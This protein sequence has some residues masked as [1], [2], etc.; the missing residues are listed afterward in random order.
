MLLSIGIKP[1]P[2]SKDLALMLELALPL[3]RKEMP[4]MH[5]AIESWM[6][7]KFMVTNGFEDHE[8]IRAGGACRARRCIGRAALFRG[9]GGTAGLAAVGRTHPRV[10][11]GGGVET[12]R[13]PARC[14]TCSPTVTNS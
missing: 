1:E 6:G 11:A 4:F 5:E 2:L 8:E 12:A 10:A 3:D 7:P 14:V 9:G 13:L